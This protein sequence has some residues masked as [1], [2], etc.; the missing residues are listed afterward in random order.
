MATSKPTQGWLFLREACQ[1]VGR[2]RGWLT[3]AF[4]E[5]K[6]RRQRNEETGLFEYKLED[7]EKYRINEDEM[8][9]QAHLMAARVAKRDAGPV[10]EKLVFVM[11]SYKEGVLTREQAVSMIRK[12]LGKP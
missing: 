3:I 1:V 7:L 6:I 12:A 11:D 8:P 9:R 10:E 4:K 2:S 5:G